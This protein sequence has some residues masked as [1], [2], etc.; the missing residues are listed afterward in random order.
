MHL[1]F[2]I[3]TMITTMSTTTMSLIITTMLTKAITTMIT[4]TMSLTK[5]TMITTD[6]S[7]TSTQETITIIP[8]TAISETLR[9][10]NSTEEFLPD[11]LTEALTRAKEAT[12]T[13]K[14][15][16]ESAFRITQDTLKQSSLVFNSIPM[17]NQEI[18]PNV[19]YLIL[20]CE[21]L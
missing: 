17:N 14:E 4:T 2:W 12:A 19:F 11:P 13:I 8:P 7:T 10:Q 18:Y 6:E 15:L 3:T 1:K 20:I 16:D 5:L 21:N 9:T